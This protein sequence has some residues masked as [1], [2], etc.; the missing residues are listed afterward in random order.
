MDDF[1]LIIF[2]LVALEA[3]FIALHFQK[4]WPACR[5]GDYDGNAFSSFQYSMDI[6]FVQP[7]FFA[8]TGKDLIA[9]FFQQ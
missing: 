3:D 8:V 2:L 1:L 6:W 4:R 9:I 5:H 7:S